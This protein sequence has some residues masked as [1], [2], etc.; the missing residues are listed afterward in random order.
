MEGHSSDPKGMREMEDAFES[1][2]GKMRPDILGTTTGW[3]PDGS[4]V[5][6]AYFTSESE[7]RKNEKKMADDP[8]FAEFMMYMDGEMTFYDLKEPVFA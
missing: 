7:A 4:F 5:T 3:E 2:M 6:V 8:R 1:E